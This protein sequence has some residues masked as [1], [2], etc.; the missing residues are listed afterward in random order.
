MPL[1]SRGRYKTHNTRTSLAKLD[2]E[3]LTPHIPNKDDRRQVVNA[4]KGVDVDTAV[5]RI[6]GLKV[7]PWHEAKYK[8][9]L[10]K[11]T[12]DSDLLVPLLENQGDDDKPI[13]LDFNEIMD[14]EAS[15]HWM[16]ASCI[17]VA[18]ATSRADLADLLD[19]H[20]SVHHD[21]PGSRQ[22]S[23]GI[24]RLSPSGL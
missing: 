24:C 11:R 2:N 4:I 21:Q 15:L 8:P 13:S 20:S 14:P 19:D 7:I 6:E 18:I 17:D 1:N 10:K 5:S 12:R 16:C 22:D 23:L 9:R 3:A